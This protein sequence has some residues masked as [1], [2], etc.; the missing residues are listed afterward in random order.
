VF[1]MDKQARSGF[2]TLIVL[3]AVVGILSGF[4]FWNIGSNAGF[5]RGIRETGTRETERIELIEEYEQRES[6]RNRRERERI[7]RTETS[8]IALESLGAG[9]RSELQKLREIHN[10]LADF[11]N[12]SRNDYLY[13]DY[14]HS[15]IGE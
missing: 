1:K 7:E 4:I 8:I 14:Y 10:I 6:D 3:L 13:R 15:D 5:D 12:N 11:Y 2:I 9:T